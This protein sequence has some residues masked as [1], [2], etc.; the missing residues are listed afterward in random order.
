MARQPSTVYPCMG[1]GKVVGFDRSFGSIRASIVYHLK[2][3]IEIIRFTYL[4]HVCITYVRAHVTSPGHVMV[5]FCSTTEKPAI[6]REGEQECE[7]TKSTSTIYVYIKEIVA[8]TR[9]AV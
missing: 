5:V 9:C 6:E 4:K 3:L 2:Q 8:D 1:H 7:T